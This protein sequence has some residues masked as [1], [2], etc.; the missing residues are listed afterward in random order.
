MPDEGG[1][2]EQNQEKRPVSFLSS[3]MMTGFFGGII[4]GTIGYLAYIFNFTEIHPNVVLDPW[5]IGSWKKTWLGTV[6]SILFIGGVSILAALIYYTAFR[7]LRGSWPGTIYG[8]LLFLLVFLVLHPIFPGIK[9]LWELDKNTLITTLCI[10]IIFGTFV[11]YSISYEYEER[12]YAKRSGVESRQ[13]RTR[14]R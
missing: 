14:L 6:I 8:A 12:E 10:Y 1:K 5:T 2:L 7:R 9:P 13:N 3:V 11:G 4:W